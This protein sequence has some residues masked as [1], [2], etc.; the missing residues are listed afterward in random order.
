MGAVDEVLAERRRLASRR[1][2]AGLF[3]ST[4]LHVALAAAVIVAPRLSA[5]RPRPIEYVAVTILP[6]QALGAPPSPSPPPERKPEP[7][8]P[9]EP[10][11]PPAKPDPEIPKLQRQVPEQPTAKKQPTPAKPTEPTPGP[12]QPDAAPTTT[13]PTDATRVGAA[14]GLASGQSA[15][16][17]PVATLDNPDFTYGYYIDQMLRLIREQWVRPPLGG[18][19]Q[20]AIHFVIHSD[21]RVT[22]VE[23]R[24]SSGYNSFDTAARRAVESA[25]PLPPLPRGYRRPTLGVTL[26]V[27]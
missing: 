6:V 1:S 27:R 17:A 16:G 7:K 3:V 19:V 8:A 22:N 15:F 24:E 9:P 26:V 18:G 11:P 13:P 5:E 10:E 25:A 20:A 12:R 4:I 23:I 21:G 2:R 14:D